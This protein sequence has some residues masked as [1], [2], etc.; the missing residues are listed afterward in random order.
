MKR[1]SSSLIIEPQIK[2]TLSYH[3]TPVRVA[4]IKIRDNKHEQACRGKADIQTERAAPVKSLREWQSVSKHKMRSRRTR[5]E[6][7]VTKEKWKTLRVGCSWAE[8]EN[9]E[10]WW[11]RFLSCLRFSRRSKSRE[12]GSHPWSRNRLLVGG[13]SRSR[14]ESRAQVREQS[15]MVKNR[16]QAR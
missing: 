13:G 14:S 9:H 2:N 7:A 1:C 16:A 4:I 15:H 6:R 5:P 8:P 10:F 12:R 3:F 11:H